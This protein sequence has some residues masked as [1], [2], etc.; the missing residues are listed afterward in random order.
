MDKA[1]LAS[2]LVR[3]TQLAVEFAR[4]YCRQELLAPATYLV[5]PNQSY[6]GNRWPDE[7]VYPEE[8]SGRRGP[9]GPWSQ[10]DVT[11][12]MWRDGNVPVWV[13]ISVFN[14]TPEAVV[15]RLL[16][17]GRWSATSARL[18]YELDGQRSPFGIKSPSL[19]PTWKEGDKFDVGWHLH[20]GA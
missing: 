1:S 18:Y 3:A 16:C 19:P 17:A 7:L 15:V 9:F 20:V 6:D 13:D 14:E 5:M 10:A 4:K 11:S 2:Q 12:W 8:Q